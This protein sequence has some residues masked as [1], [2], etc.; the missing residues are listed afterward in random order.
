M[1]LLRFAYWHV[2]YFIF[3]RFIAAWQWKRLA[4]VK[5][6]PGTKAPFSIG[7]VT[8]I[9]RY[10]KF[11]EPLIQKLAVLLPEVEIVVMVNG[12]YDQELQQ[13]YLQKITAL[14]DR[15][16]NVKYVTHTAP[17]GLSTLW[18]RIV[19]HSSEQNVFIMNDDIC[20]SPGFREQIFGM[21]KK[22]ITLIN[23]SWSHFLITRE[24]IREFGWFDE[25][26]T[27]VGNEDQDYDFRLAAKNTIPA[28]VLFSTIRNVVVQTRDFS[29]GKNVQTVNR[30]YTAGNRE[31]FDSKWETSETEKP[32]MVFSRKFGVWFN[33]APKIPSPDFHPEIKL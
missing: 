32:G 4:A 15:F 6:T 7:I 13:Q 25:R 8:Y 12:Y 19:I 21:E 11:F 16:E 31:F 18:N 28:D 29:Y 10:E 22:T 17:Q 33:P 14:L 24:V 26:Y 1:K 2:R 3:W 27:G 30:K 9:A 5:K 20:I 23:N